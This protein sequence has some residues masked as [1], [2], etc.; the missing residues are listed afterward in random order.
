MV[1]FM[2]MLKLGFGFLVVAVLIMAF[3]QQHQAQD[4]LHGENDA[5]RH[6]LAELQAENAGLSNRLTDEGVFKRR[7]SA[8]LTELLKLRGDVGLLR[9][10]VG[11]IGKLRDELQR[12]ESAPGISPTL[13]ASMET[14]EQ[15]QQAALASLNRAHHGMLGFIM[16]ADENQ[17][18]FPASFAEAAPFIKEGLEPI[19]LNFEIVYVGSLTNLT[20]TAGTIVLREKAPSRT[21]DGKWQKTYGFAD[22]HAEVHTEPD[23]NFDVWESQHIIPPPPPN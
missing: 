15:Q 14:L 13:Q 16:F 23:G 1:P 11:E 21:R 5:L 19:A 2:K 22:G 6:Q 4:R 12:R 3:V 18:Q 8:Q 17:Q 9:Q 7:A 20:N 10:Q